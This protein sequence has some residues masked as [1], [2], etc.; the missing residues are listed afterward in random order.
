MNIF[1]RLFSSN[2]SDSQTTGSPQSGR[3]GLS[4]G[5]QTLGRQS[6]RT[7]NNNN[8]NPTMTN[9]ASFADARNSMSSP[10]SGIQASFA[11]GGN[12]SDTLSDVSLTAD[13]FEEDRK[14]CAEFVYLGEEIKFE[15]LIGDEGDDSLSTKSGKGGS[16]STSISSSSSTSSSSNTS[17]QGGGRWGWLPGRRNS[18]GGRGI[19]GNGNSSSTATV[20]PL[21]RKYLEQ[22]ERDMRRDFRRRMA[23]FRTATEPQMVEFLAVGGPPPAMRLVP[24]PEAIMV[25]LCPG[26]AEEFGMKGEEKEG[27]ERADAKLSSEIMGRVLTKCGRTFLYTVQVNSSYLDPKHWPVHSAEPT[28]EESQGYQ[29]LNESLRKLK[30]TEKADD[31]KKKESTDDEEEKDS[32]RDSNKMSKTVSE[33]SELSSLSFRQLGPIRGF[34]KLDYWDPEKYLDK[35]SPEWEQKTREVRTYRR[36]VQR[37]YYATE[38]DLAHDGDFTDIYSYTDFSSRTGG[39]LGRGPHG[40]NAAASG[41]G[42][43]ADGP[44]RGRR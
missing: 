37:H 15:I 21:Q 43:K 42:A 26:Y 18:R 14:A 29:D 7:N 33:D 24:P 23:H 31:D 44:L 10:L 1:K 20:V 40:P 41:A 13:L 27:S 17:E 9:N 22:H 4:S 38:M 35:D 39:R 5:P 32:K 8:N 36:L 25:D 3:A 28:A 30:E 6:S 2:T 34:D 12:G 19:G 16:N 11:S